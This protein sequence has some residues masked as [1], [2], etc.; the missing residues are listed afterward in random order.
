M[1]GP[2]T[3]I[4]N[5]RR[6]ILSQGIQGALIGSGAS[7][8]VYEEGNKAKKIVFLTPTNLNELAVVALLMN[9]SDQPDGIIRYH[10]V[11]VDRKQKILSILMD[12]GSS[13]LA[14]L[15]KKLQM[16]ERFEMAASVMKK[17]L[18][19]LASMQTF[20]PYIVHGDLR[21]ENIVI[22]GDSLK[23]IDFGSAIIQTKSSSAKTI[24]RGSVY[25]FAP[26][27]CFLYDKHVPD[28]YDVRNF[29]TYS[30]AAMMIYWLFKEHLV[31]R[32]VWSSDSAMREFHRDGTCLRQSIKYIEMRYMNII[33]TNLIDG[34]WDLVKDMI[35]E[36]PTKR[37]LA[38]D[39]SDELSELIEK[40]KRNI[41]ENAIDTDIRRLDMD[42]LLS[43]D[44]FKGLE[45]DK[46]TQEK[47]A[48]VAE[49]LCQ[50]TL[51]MT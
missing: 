16:K 12:R 10:S 29:D 6:R 1:I 5:K 9:S 30:V 15:A 13:T 41:F 28:E 45:V 14:D 40:S 26:P 36:H 25:E 8:D 24:P 48:D 27:E 23:I 44:K 46:W 50:Q 38:V 17:M 34:M 33:E 3:M 39:I 2:N 18:D 19:A 31:D 11:T 35:T 22:I 47:M 51:E 7:G 49:F 20:K 21:L 37:K 32:K 43:S 4:M 42:L